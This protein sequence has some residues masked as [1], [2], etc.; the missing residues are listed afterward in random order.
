MPAAELLPKE[1]LERSRSGEVVVL[2]VRTALEWRA[3]HIPGAV[4][5]PVDELPGRVA[6]LDPDRETL[7]VCA[8]GI[9]SAAAAAWLAQIGFERV[10]NVRHGLSRW[11]EPLGTRDT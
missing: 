3:G 2:D 1:A 8:H 6:E 4:H 11:P 9:R 10:Y 5:I 7:V